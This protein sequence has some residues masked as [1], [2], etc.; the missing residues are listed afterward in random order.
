MQIILDR[1]S[2]A[3]SRAR[4]ASQLGKASKGSLQQTYCHSGSCPEYSRAPASGVG[5]FASREKSELLLFCHRDVK[6]PTV[7]R[8]QH[9]YLRLTRVI[10]LSTIKKPGVTTLQGW[11]TTAGDTGAPWRFGR[12]IS[13][14]EAIRA[15]P[16]R[17][18]RRI[19]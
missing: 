9:A 16:Q 17:S 14:P 18:W 7:R 13:L 19:S 1:Q 3:V 15:I 12:S 4:L 5:A 6:R 11:E 8:R 10:F 2:G